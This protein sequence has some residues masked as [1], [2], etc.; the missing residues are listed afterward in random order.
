M[1][2]VTLRRVRIGKAAV[3]YARTVIVKNTKILSLA[4]KFIYGEYRRKQH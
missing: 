3:R 2:I 4:Q 1:Y